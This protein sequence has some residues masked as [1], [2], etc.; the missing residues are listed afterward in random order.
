ME[1]A[2]A[3][4]TFSCPLP[5]KFE[6]NNI[7]REVYPPTDN[8]QPQI[9]VPNTGNTSREKYREQVGFPALSYA[10]SDVPSHSANF[11]QVGLPIHH[12]N[13]LDAQGVESTEWNDQVRLICFEYF[14]F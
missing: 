2:D 6:E 7:R 13:G 12:T 14:C 5:P 4:E 1:S 8:H 11:H 10:P 3:T 9:V